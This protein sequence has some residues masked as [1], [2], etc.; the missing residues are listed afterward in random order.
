MTSRLPGFYALP[1]EERLRVVAELCGLTPEEVQS[2][3]PGGG[4]STERADKMIENALGILALPL[5]IATNFQING[6]DYLV[7]MSVEEPS[8]VASA[9]NMAKI[10]RTAGGFATEASERRMVGQV[11]VVNCPDF[12]EGREKLMGRAQALL[13]IANASQPK[14][15]ARGGGALELDV[16]LL[17]HQSQDPWPEMLVVQVIVDTRDAMGANVIDTMMEAIA[18]EVERI[19]GGTVYLRILSNYTDQCLARARCTVPPALLAT[20][21]LS[22]E[23][24]RDRIVSAYAFAESDVYRA[25]THNKGI[26][27]GVDAVALATGQDWRAIEAGAH[28]CASVAAT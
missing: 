3:A 10:V 16:R 9:S 24:V 12:L 2:L 26:M 19:S 18:P 23:E 28:A 11:Q 13:D 14:M 6:R 17:N 8:I 20:D 4:L 15:K 25:V 22:G 7:P 21:R 27:N 1:V 5:G